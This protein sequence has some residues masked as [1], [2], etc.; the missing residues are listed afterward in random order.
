MRNQVHSHPPK[1]PTGGTTG[2]SHGESSPGAPQNKA[3]A[4]GTGEAGAERAQG[5]GQAADAFVNSKIRAAI[6]REREGELRALRLEKAGLL[7]TLWAAGR[8]VNPCRNQRP[9]GAS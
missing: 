9:I 1:P 3:V 8:T 4:P 2:R 7:L 6:S 5:P